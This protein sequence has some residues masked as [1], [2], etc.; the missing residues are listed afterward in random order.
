MVGLQ[1]MNDQVIRLTAVQGLLHVGH[2]LVG[3]TAVH[4]IH[5]GDFVIQNDIG[6]VRHTVRYNI[7]TFKQVDFVVIYSHIANI[8]CDFHK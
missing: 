8:I 3:G 1:V 4:G 6:I 5:D 2:P 7:L